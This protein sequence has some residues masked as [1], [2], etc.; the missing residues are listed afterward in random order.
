MKIEFYIKST[1]NEKHIAEML[2]ISLTLKELRIH[3]I[4]IN[5]IAFPLSTIRKDLLRFVL[6]DLKE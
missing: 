2:A 6:R 3:T 5:G 4:W 1:Y